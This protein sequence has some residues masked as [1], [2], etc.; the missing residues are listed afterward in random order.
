MPTLTAEVPIIAAVIARV[1]IGC[2][3]SKALP[4]RVMSSEL[5]LRLR[6]Y[7]G[8]RVFDSSSRGFGSLLLGLLFGF[9][10][11]FEFGIRVSYG[12]LVV[13]V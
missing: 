7:F 1:D 4:S 2:L 3:G 11:G 9:L 12:F 6:L 13:W 10:V 8:V 5:H